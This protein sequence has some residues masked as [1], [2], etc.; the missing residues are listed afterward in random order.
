MLM[1]YRLLNWQHD[2]SRKAV[3]LG[4][5]VTDVNNALVYLV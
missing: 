5:S 3:E 1:L 4:N 2:A